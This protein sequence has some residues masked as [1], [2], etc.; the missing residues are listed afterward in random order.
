MAK[1]F[2]LMEAIPCVSSRRVLTTDDKQ[3]ALE[4]QVKKMKE[5]PD[6]VYYIEYK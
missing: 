3:K 5:N 4:L 1:R 6:W 2:I